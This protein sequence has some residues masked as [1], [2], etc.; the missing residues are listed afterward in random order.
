MHPLTPE[1]LEFWYISCVVSIHELRFILRSSEI[2]VT[3]WP[4]KIL[5]FILLFTILLFRN[6]PP[7]ASVSTATQ[8]LLRVVEEYPSGPPTLDPINDLHLRDLDLV[9]QFHRLKFIESD[10]DKYDCVDHPA[11]QDN[12][13]LNLKKV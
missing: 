13:S 12:V 3:E 11:F 5:P 1:L 2:T 9:E 8:D 10:F 7:G 6:D 4:S